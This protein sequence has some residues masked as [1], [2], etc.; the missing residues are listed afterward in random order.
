MFIGLYHSVSAVSYMVSSTLSEI[1]IYHVCFLV[2]QKKVGKDL[3]G[4]IKEGFEQVECQNDLLIN[5][6]TFPFPFTLTTV[7]AI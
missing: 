6:M 3:P 2:S 1:E 5:T 7:G 4:Y